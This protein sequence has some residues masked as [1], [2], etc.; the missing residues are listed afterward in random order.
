MNFFIKIYQKEDMS[1]IVQSNEQSKSQGAVLTS[2]AEI[3]GRWVSRE[4]LA[5]AAF[6]RRL[7][8]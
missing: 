2:S 5:T 8:E 7:E 6:F 4:V 1:R 3:T